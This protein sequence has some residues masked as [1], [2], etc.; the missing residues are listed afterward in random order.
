MTKISILIATYN[1]A[2]L[3][4][5]AAQSALQ[6]PLDDLEVI[7]VDDGSTDDTRQALAQITDARVKYLYQENQGAA[8]AWNRGFQY[9]TGEYIGILG[10]DDLYLPDGLIPLV[11]LL[12]KQ[13][14]LGVAGGGFIYMDQD[15]KILKE[16]Q[17]WRNC[18]TLGLET[19]L[20][21]C[22]ILLQSSLIRR[23]WFDRV[24]GFDINLKIGPDD[25]DFFL[26]LAGAACA[27]AWVEALVFYYRIHTSRNFLE[28]PMRI[29]KVFYILDKFFNT[30][31]LPAEVLEKRN[32]AYFR[33]YLN[34]AG[35]NF[36][37]GFSEDGR[38]MLQN[39]IEMDAG[40]L[41]NGGRQLF[42]NIAWWALSPKHSQSNREFI[43]Y[44]LQNL[45]EKA[46]KFRNSTRQV[47]A[48]QAAVKFF[49]AYHL[50]DI[51]QTKLALRDMLRNHPTR[52]LDRGVLSIGV[53]VI[54]GKRMTGLLREIF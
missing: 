40:F 29:E 33:A 44:V 45:P 11:Q 12:D 47:L 52:C 7:V 21:A 36:A 49:Q 6:Q 46:D 2:E 26:R 17:P 5:K 38:Q 30:P 43:R 54:L 20:F 48:E 3:V 8:A 4:K 25:W 35:H 32:A 34:N 31:G 41:A 9:S 22:P 13:P 27:M 19:W 1:R 53:E 50:Q 15:G 16:E 39:A 18:P 24:G 51:P 10:D 28:T 23:E 42:H 14:D 37:C